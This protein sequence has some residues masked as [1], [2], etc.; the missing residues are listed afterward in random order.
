M[1]PGKLKTW[2]NK[3]THATVI[4]EMA[5][6]LTLHQIWWNLNY[7]AKCHFLDR[8][9]SEQK[10]QRRTDVYKIFLCHDSHEISSLASPGNMA[11]TDFSFITSW[12]KN[13]NA[14]MFSSWLTFQHISKNITSPSLCCIWSCSFLSGIQPL[15]FVA[16]LCQRQQHFS[17]SCPSMANTRQSLEAPF[18]PDIIEMTLTNSAGYAFLPPCGWRLQTKSRYLLWL[19]NFTFGNLYFCCPFTIFVNKNGSNLNSLFHYFLWFVYFN[20]WEKSE[21]GI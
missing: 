21:N 4:T 16:S 2:L 5:A 17:P 20:C 1:L 6:A 11:W 10:S 7:S 14:K 13:N 18:S 3:H 19:I 15:W 12:T 9:Q 8:S